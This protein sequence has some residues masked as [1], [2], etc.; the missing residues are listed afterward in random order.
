MG[1]VSAP[2]V[3]ECE[4]VPLAEIETRPAAKLMPLVEEYEETFGTLAADVG[5]TY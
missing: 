1:A 3:P 2:V 5:T 4:T